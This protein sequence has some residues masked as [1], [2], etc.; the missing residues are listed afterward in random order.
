MGCWGMGVTQS[1]E[2]GEVYDRFMEEYDEGK[3]VS[4]ITKDILEEYLEE[5]ESDDG[6]LHDVY[7]ALGKAE[8]MCGGI[9]DEIFEKIKRIVEAGEN[10]AF[11]RELEAT[12]QDLKMRKKNLE[13]FLHNLSVPRGKVKK[14][15]VP[16]EKYV[17]KESGNLSLAKVKRYDIYAYK[18]DGKYRAF[19][20]IERTKIDSCTAVFVYAW[21]AV[22]EEIPTIEQLLKEYIKP[23][24]WFENKTFPDM[25]K[26]TLIGNYPQLK[27]LCYVYPKALH[28]QWKLVTW[29]WAKEENLTEEYPLELCVRLE[30]IFEKIQ[31]LKKLYEQR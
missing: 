2:F 3:P 15:K 30:E 8:W 26:L 10:I 28:K 7:F 25:E 24:G 21:R 22:F 4:D 18:N 20:L 13:K 1:D 5:F 17:S 6:V 9:S 29:D 27:E 19:A 11:Y 31:E 12:E 23:V 16:E 14:R